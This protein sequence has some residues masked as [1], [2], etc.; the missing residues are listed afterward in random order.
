MVIEG[1]TLGAPVIVRV[2]V[3][4]TVCVP[5]TDGEIVLVI[6]LLGVT[7]LVTV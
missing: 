7:V 5:V 1:L 2:I 4:E 6:V 3:W